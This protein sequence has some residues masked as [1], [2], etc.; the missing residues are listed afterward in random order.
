[1]VIL[2]SGA[3]VE[4]LT[5]DGNRAKLA[6]PLPIAPYDRAFAEFYANNGILSVGTQKSQSV[7]KAEEHSELRSDRERSEERDHRAVHVSES[8]SLNDKG[9]NNTTGG[10]LL[11]EGTT[12]FVVAELRLRKHSR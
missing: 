7:R 1:M 8:G 3:T 9:R 2:G 11:E 6:K 5:I 12:G 10:I 4:R